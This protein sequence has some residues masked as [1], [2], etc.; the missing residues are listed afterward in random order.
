MKRLLSATGVAL[1][2]ALLLTG[3]G[4]G[5]K[6]ASLSSL[7]L[8]TTVLSFLALAAYLTLV[9]DKIRWLLLLFCA[10]PL[11]NIGYCWLSLSQTL[12]SALWANR[13]SYLGSV[14]L[15]LAMLM[16]I[17]HVANLRYPRWLPWMLIGISGFVFLVAASPGFSD[18]YYQSVTLETVGGC[19]TLNKVYG[20][21]HPLYLIF[22]LGYFATMV[23]AIVHATV[24]KTV[25]TNIQAVLLAIAVFVNIGVWLLGQFSKLDFEFLSV[26]YIISELFLLGLQLLI[27]DGDKLFAVPAD[28][29]PAP[30]DEENAADPL[31]EALALFSTGLAT[32]TPTEHTVYTYYTEGK[33]TKEVL[34]LLHITENTLKYHNRNLYSKLGV[35]SRKQLKE[36]ASH[37]PTE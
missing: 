15:P 23:A 1:L 8:A 36:L 12:D 7:Y 3:C 14:M 33:S 9:R 13:L 24:K 37:L 34:E 22:L 11:V 18:I 20:P 16:T 35:S 19:S 28:T 25:R 32:L 27:Q 6:S 2:S 29:P 21:W 26:S 31:A 4:V 5:D 30:G 10:V 17:L